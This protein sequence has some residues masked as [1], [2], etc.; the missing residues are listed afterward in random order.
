[1]PYDVHMRM[2]GGGVAIMRVAGQRPR[3]CVK[4]GAQSTRLCD[5]KTS[6]GKVR[7]RRCSAP[8]CDSCTF[9]PAPKKDLCPQHAEMW[10][11][12]SSVTQSRQVVNPPADEAEARNLANTAPRQADSDAACRG[13]IGPSSEPEARPVMPT[14]QFNV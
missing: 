3:P 8:V 14:A 5:W 2:P 10:A 13:E 7:P 4:C 11:A 1:M 12:R 9:S 6:G